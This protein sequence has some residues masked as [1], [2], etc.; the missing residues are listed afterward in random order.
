MTEIGTKQNQPCLSE[1][2]ADEVQE[3]P[4]QPPLHSS[5]S[6][7]EAMVPGVSCPLQDYLRAYQD[8]LKKVTSSLDI[9]VE[10]VKKSPIV[11]GLQDLPVW[12]CL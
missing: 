8:L 9:Q 3:A 2:S 6:P 4:F 12:L 10:V 1:P 11:W 7:D 5:S